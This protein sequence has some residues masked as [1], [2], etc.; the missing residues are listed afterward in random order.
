MQLLLVELHDLRDHAVQEVLVV[1]DDHHG[2]AVVGQVFL[3]PFDRR[4]VE[5]VG[6]FVEQKQV[7]L[8][9]D[10]PGE[11]HTHPPPPAELTVGPL[12]VLGCES[13]TLQDLLRAMM[14]GV[15]VER[16][17]LGQHVGVGLQLR[18][19]VL[20]LQLPAQCFDA[21]LQFEHAREGSHGHAQDR[22][23]RVE[24]EQV[25][26]QVAYRGAPAPL[27]ASGGGKV[28]AD[29]E[30]EQR[31]LARAVVAD[32]SDP[33]VG[34]DVPGGIPEDGSRPEL[35]SDVLQTGQHGYVF[36]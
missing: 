2:P 7:W 21:A 1:A 35:E 11:Q 8:L 34:L 20:L 29:E 14:D 25:L 3:Q 30:L 33:F 4:Q 13:E 31:R 5:V 19:V 12:V 32:E 24:A 17:H 23:T 27:H 22:F 16:V 9:E 6:G 36:P 28:L 10:H 18:L 15:S 26:V